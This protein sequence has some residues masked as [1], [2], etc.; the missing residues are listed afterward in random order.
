M[1]GGKKSFLLKPFVLIGQTLLLTTT[2]LEGKSRSHEAVHA[3]FAKEEA[4]LL[5]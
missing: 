4:S 2:N 3:Q 5:L 1:E